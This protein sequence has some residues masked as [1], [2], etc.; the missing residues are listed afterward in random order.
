MHSRRNAPQ[1]RGRG[2]GGQGP[3]LQKHLGESVTT[4]ERALRLVKPI[5]P[6]LY[7][8]FQNFDLSQYTKNLDKG[9]N[10]D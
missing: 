4:S 9:A 7:I 6:D 5:M 2:V 8:M 1:P 10:L 3:R